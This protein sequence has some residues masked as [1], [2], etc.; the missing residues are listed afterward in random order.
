MFG[1][2]AACEMFT[3]ITQITRAVQIEKSLG[4]FIGSA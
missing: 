2:S 4:S 3:N 1:R